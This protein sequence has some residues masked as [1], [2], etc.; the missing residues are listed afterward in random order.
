MHHY[1]THK[2]DF[3]IHTEYGV[4]HICAECWAAHP[5]PPQFMKSTPFEK[6]DGRQC[7]CEHISHYPDDKPSVTVDYKP[8]DP[9]GGEL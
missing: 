6:S 7:E 3:R 8:F 1:E 5:I 4:Y 2:A 9:D